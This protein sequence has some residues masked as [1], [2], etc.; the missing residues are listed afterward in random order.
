MC[1]LLVMTYDKTNKDKDK[2]RMCPKAGMTLIVKSDGWKWSKAEQGPGYKVIKM[3]GVP[4]ADVKKYWQEEWE[5]TS[6]DWED[7]DSSHYRYRRYRV[8]VESWTAADDTYVE[9]GLTSNANKVAR[10]DSKTEDM[11]PGLDP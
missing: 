9:A 4:V 10:L 6:G 7:E 5:T 2:D 3:K 1:E 8:E 11:K